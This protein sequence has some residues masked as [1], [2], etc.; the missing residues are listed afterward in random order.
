MIYHFYQK[1]KE[2][3]MDQTFEKL[4]LCEK[5]VKFSKIVCKEMKNN[6]ILT[7][8]MIGATITRLIAV[9]FSTYLILWI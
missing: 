5:S 4:S 9:L 8:C 7:L 3:N 2:K 6:S 1:K